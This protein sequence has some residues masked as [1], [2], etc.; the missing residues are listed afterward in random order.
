MRFA[1]SDVG[2][3]WVR[4]ERRS[5]NDKPEGIR[6]PLSDP[7]HDLVIAHLRLFAKRLPGA[8]NVL[9]SICNREHIGEVAWDVLFHEQFEPEFDEF[10]LAVA[11]ELLAQARLLAHFGPLLGRP[12]VDTLNGSS[13]ANMKELRFDAANGVWRVAFAFY[14]R[15]NAILLV[16]GD[17]AGVSQKRFYRQMITK[18]DARLD[19]HVA[20][21]DRKRKNHESVA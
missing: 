13:H 7:D 4:G 14:P 17:K 21:L 1:F 9:D 18:A 11:D 5:L 2:N 16:A 8:A 15:R 10:P 20:A 19:E 6:N 12:R 3:N